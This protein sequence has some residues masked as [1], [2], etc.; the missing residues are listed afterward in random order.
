MPIDKVLSVSIANAAI[1]AS[2]ISNTANLVIGALNTGNTVVTGTQFVNGA[3]TFANSTS[4]TVYVAGNGNI[5]IGTGVINDQLTDVLTLSKNSSS[6]DIKLIIRQH[7]DNTAAQIY[8]VANNDAGAAYNNIRSFTQ[9]GTQ[10]WKLGGVGGFTGGLAIS[11]SGTEKVRI[12]ANG[13]LTTP[14]QPLVVATRSGDLTGYNQTS[15]GLATV[16]NATELN[17]G[18]NYNTSTGLL[19]APASGTYVYY[20]SAYTGGPPTMQQIWP[21][22]NGNRGRSCSV[23]AGN[24]VVAGMGMIYLSVNDSFGVHFYGSNT[25]ATISANFYHTFLQIFFLG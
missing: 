21:V 20:T 5:A 12:A 4:N 9:G 18:N 23:I 22:T 10:H 3:V 13:V 25:N 16:F 1:N 6:N 24:D 19:T 8:M 14:Y 15:G 7:G 17:V 2:A 11:T